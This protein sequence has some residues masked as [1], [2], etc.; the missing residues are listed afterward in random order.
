MQVLVGVGLFA[1]SVSAIT[2]VSVAHRSHDIIVLEK[3]QIGQKVL[4][5]TGAVF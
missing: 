2:L 4:M 3:L 5:I 1:G